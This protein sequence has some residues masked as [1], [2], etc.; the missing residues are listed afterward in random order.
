MF[1][2]NEI[3]DST[4]TFIHDIEHSLKDATT[5]IKSLSSKLT[6]TID[7]SADSAFGGAKQT[8]KTIEQKKED[9]EKKL[10]HFRESADAAA[11]DIKIGLQIAWTD[12]RDT[13][14]SVQDR[15]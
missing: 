11:E 14:K 2:K 10:A 8:L 7:D 9:V 15:F 1:Q 6:Q 12:L 4:K 3:K 5:T 13:M